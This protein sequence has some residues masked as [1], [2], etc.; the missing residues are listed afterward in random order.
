M[1]NGGVR[2]DVN[3]I[4]LMGGSWAPLLAINFSH[5][6]EWLASLGL[7]MAILA[8]FF[9]VIDHGM[10]IH[11]KLKQKRKAK[12]NGGNNQQKTDDEQ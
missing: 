9:A 3:E 4:L 5:L 11:W 12:D 8:S 6:N 1:Y 7:C 10:K 2:S